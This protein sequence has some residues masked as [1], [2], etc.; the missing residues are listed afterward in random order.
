VI[1]ALE[2][3]ATPE[4]WHPGAPLWRQVLWRLVGLPVLASAL[5]GTG[6]RKVLLRLFGARIGRGGRIKPYLH[7]TSPWRL[8]LG[9]HCWLGERL[10]IDNLAPVTIGRRV[11]LSQ[12]AYLC[13]GN[14]DFRS[15]GFSLRAA[16]ICIED[17]AWVAAQA[18][19]GP[20]IHIGAGAVIGLAA[21]VTQDVSA[22]AILR[23]NPARITGQR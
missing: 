15:P 10:W 22:R 2:H 8:E 4:D 12:G 17:E 5:P 3:Y 19:L 14:H 21:V 20:G 6:W 1:Q 13:T 23:G 11:C 16:P 9:D 18:V 7:I